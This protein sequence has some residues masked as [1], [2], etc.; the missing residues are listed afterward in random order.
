MRVRLDWDVLGMSA[1]DEGAQ[2][3]TFAH[4]LMLSMHELLTSQHLTDARHKYSTSRSTFCFYLK[5]FTAFKICTPA[6]WNETSFFTANWRRLI[7]PQFSYCKIWLMSGSACRWEGRLVLTL[8]VTSA[9]L[10]EGRG[11]RWLAAI[12]LI[13]RGLFPAPGGAGGGAGY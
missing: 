4:T 5:W 8:S 9:G 1:C 11:G 10:E 3:E 12:S 6:A 2:N 7:F 13:I